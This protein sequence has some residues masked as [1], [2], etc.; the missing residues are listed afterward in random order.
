V[1]SFRPPDMDG[2]GVAMR[3]ATEASSG[4]T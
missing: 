4:S 2:R 3:V 1:N